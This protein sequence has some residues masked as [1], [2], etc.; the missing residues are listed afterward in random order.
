MSCNKEPYLF[1]IY[2]AKNIEIINCIFGDKVGDII[3]VPLYCLRNTTGLRIFS[4]HE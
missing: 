4:Y 3:V 2:F 1:K